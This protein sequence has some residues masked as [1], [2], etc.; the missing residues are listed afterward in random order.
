MILLNIDTPVEKPFAAKA[1][2]IG[3]KDVIE[4]VVIAYN[5]ILSR[6]K[7]LENFL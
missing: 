1:D 5:G 6:R 2:F 4:M 7:K 3:E